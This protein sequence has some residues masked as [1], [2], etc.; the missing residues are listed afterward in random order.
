[1]EFDWP[2]LSERETKINPLVLAKRN[3]ACVKMTVV[4][5]QVQYSAAARY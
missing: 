5:D 2:F 1:M 4:G 3:L